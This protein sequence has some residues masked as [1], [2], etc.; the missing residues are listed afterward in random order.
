M[1]PSLLLRLLREQG[2]LYL[3][4]QVVWVYPRLPG[5]GTLADPAHHALEGLRVVFVGA[6]G[7]LPEKI[8]LGLRCRPLPTFTGF[9]FVVHIAGVFLNND[10]IFLEIFVRLLWSLCRV[11]NSVCVGSPH[12]HQQGTWPEEQC[13]KGTKTTRALTTQKKTYNFHTS[14]QKLKI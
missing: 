11:F 9:L 5:G 12:R 7:T 2:L 6:D 13:G 1:S 3:D 4:G 14:F 8:L 10:R